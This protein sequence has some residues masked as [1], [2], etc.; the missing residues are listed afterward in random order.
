MPTLCHSVGQSPGRSNSWLRAPS[1][2]ARHSSG[3]NARIG[4]DGCCELRT[5]TTPSWNATSTH[6]SGPLLH[7]LD[8][9]HPRPHLR[10]LSTYAPACV[11]GPDALTRALT[12]SRLLRAPCRPGRPPAG[13]NPTLLSQCKWS[14]AVRLRKAEVWYAA[15]AR[16]SLRSRPQSILTQAAVTCNIP[17]ESALESRFLNSKFVASVDMRRGKLHSGSHSLVGASRQETQGLPHRIGTLALL[18]CATIQGR[19]TTM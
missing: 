7:E 9:S 4:P 14:K 15:A 6:V 10:L 17:V 19:Y 1:R 18:S 8:R 11:D 3:V 16:T 2:N 12:S 13:A 5:R